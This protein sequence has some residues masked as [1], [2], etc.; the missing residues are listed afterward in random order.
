MWMQIKDKFFSWQGSSVP[1]GGEA[2]ETCAADYMRKK[3]YRVVARNWRNPADRREEID[4]IC[5]DGDILVF[6]EVKTRSAKAKVPGYYTVNKRKKTVLLRACRAYLGSLREKPDT[7]RFDV[8]EVST[9]S[10]AAPEV[11]HFEN[12]PLF[13]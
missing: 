4:L 12:V 2:G 3:G 10:G 9:R 5:L 8:I 13:P 11:L 6:I 7:Y 1:T